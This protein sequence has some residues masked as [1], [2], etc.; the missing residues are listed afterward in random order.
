MS[1]GRTARA[2]IARLGRRVSG[3]IHA[4]DH[5][6]A[7]TA[8]TRRVLVD[9]RTPVTHAV[10][11][12][13]YESLQQ[14]P[15]IQVSFT[16]E[17]PE[18]ISPL[19]DRSRLLTHADA[20][21]RRFDLYMNADPWGAPRLRRCASRVNFFHGVAGKYDLDRPEGLPM[22]FEY[23]DRVAF[24]N[25]DRM[26]RYLE[27]RVV[28]ARQA[29]LIGYP[30]LDRLVT[31]GL[32]GAKVREA[33]AL[34]PRPTALY[35]PTYSPASSLHIAGDEIVRALARSGWNVL[36]KLHDRSLD[37]DRRYTGG[38]DWRSRML[39]LESHGQVRY[40]E[41]PDASPYLAAAD[42]MVT[43]HSS[44]GFEFLVLDRPLVVFDAP[45]LGD[46]ARINPEKIALLR[47]AALVVENVQALAAGAASE[48]RAPAARSARRQRVA[49]DIFHE[50]GTATLRAVALLRELLALTT[51]PRGVDLAAA[52]VARGQAS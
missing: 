29:A 38:I 31:G 40:V 28:T 22:G 34:G 2:V 41:G 43:D 21:W 39:A 3:A 15:A 49:A 46:T 45:R 42:L 47:S 36:I 4:L 20:E 1:N 5:A 32:D 19:V 17:Y 26:T 11:A 30:K 8:R 6:I 13:V 18:R 48:L 37:G 14:D 25:R 35:A 10:L 50:P 51:S 33:L 44:V 12:P 7:R 24:I 52:H 9:I 27:A 16:S 23:Y